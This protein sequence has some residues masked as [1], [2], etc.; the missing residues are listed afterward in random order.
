MS[1]HLQRVALTGGIATGKSVC[2]RRFA[3]LGAPTIDADGLARD[4]VAPGTP[5]LRAI[6]DRFGRE[7]MRADGTLDRA[8]LGQLVFNDASARAALE[9]I[10]HPAVYGAIS[11]WFDDR[12]R[13]AARGG[14]RA[15]VADIPLL[16]ET[17]REREFDRVVVAACPAALQ[18]DRLMTRDGLSEA[19]ARRRID[20][21]WPI[22]LKRS[23]ADVVIDT[24]G[25]LVET[26][27]QVDRVWAEL[28]G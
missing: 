3:A 2:L 9:R 28:R 27:Q 23:R 11:A 17:G 14:P 8:R 7:I 24:S 15:A 19:D 22:E 26:E 10:I 21:Q 5:Q 18:L 12:E 4:V 1:G 6:E 25:T 13:D 20:A 16:F